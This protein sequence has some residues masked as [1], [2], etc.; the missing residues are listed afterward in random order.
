[1]SVSKSKYFLAIALVLGVAASS[2]CRLDPAGP[3]LLMIVLLGSGI[4]SMIAALQGKWREV[5]PILIFPLLA[6]VFFPTLIDRCRT[7]T[8]DD[9]AVITLKTIEAAE[10]T[11]ESSN[12]AYGSLEQLIHAGL[13]GSRYQGTVAGYRFEVEVPSDGKTFRAKAIRGSPQNGRYNYFVLADGTV[14]YSADAA[15]PNRAGQA[16]P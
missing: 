4:S 1:M 6:L 12:G 11:Y 8:N 9:S 7:R 13:I 2:S 16:V 3:V 5:G 10:K 15:P 14:R